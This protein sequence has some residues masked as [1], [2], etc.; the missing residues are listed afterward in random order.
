MSYR[1]PSESDLSTYVIIKSPFLKHN[2]S[3]ASAVTITGAG[4]ALN[5]KIEPACP[6][7]KPRNLPKNQTNTK[8]GYLKQY[9]Y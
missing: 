5:L 2:V 7:L 3:T 6:Q 1:T 4:L 9:Q 8:I